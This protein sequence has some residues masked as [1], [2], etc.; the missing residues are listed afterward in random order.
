MAAHTVAVEMDQIPVAELLPQYIED[1][2]LELSGV[3]SLWAASKTDHDKDSYIF[4]QKFPL[5]FTDDLIFHTEVVVCPKDSFSQG[6]QAILDGKA[7]SLTDFVELDETWWGTKTMSCV[8]MG[9]GGAP[10]TSEC[11]AVP[12]GKDQTDFALN[13]RRAVIGNADTSKKSLFLYGTGTFD[14][15]AAY[16]KLC[17]SKCWSNWAGT[18]Y[19][20]LTNNCNTFTSTVLHCV[21]GLS[22][23]KPHL[24]VSDMIT[25][26]G[27]CPSTE[28]GDAKSMV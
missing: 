20:P 28:G 26:S 27:H 22:Q 23:K 11:C 24:G 17:S 7:K 10:C 6:D 18:D 15:F 12:H 5:Q 8:E 25:V 1:R 2:P 13:A 19:N 4:L 14:G 3:P 21:Y 16:E 9:Y